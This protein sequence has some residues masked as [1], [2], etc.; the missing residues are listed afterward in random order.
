VCEKTICRLD[1]HCVY[2][3][4]CV[5]A[6]N[7][8][9]FVAMLVAELF[10]L[11]LG[12]VIVW[13]MLGTLTVARGQPASAMIYIA[14][15]LMAVFLLAVATLLLAALNRVRMNATVYEMSAKP[16][17]FRFGNKFDMGLTENFNECL[18]VSVSA[19]CAARQSQNAARPRATRMNRNTTKS[20]EQPKPLL[21]WFERIIA[22]H[23]TVTTGRDAALHEVSICRSRTQ[24]ARPLT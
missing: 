12:C 6:L 17:Y 1:H 21:C 11:S 5:G 7:L 4:A 3:N 16:D 10:H 19:V 18:L 22:S 14:F 15:T 13:Q 2:L 24:S 23:A 20:L 9:Y 8:R